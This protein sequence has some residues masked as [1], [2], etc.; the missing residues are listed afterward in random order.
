MIQYFPTDP[1]LR[2]KLSRPINETE[3]R[4]SIR[5]AA[6]FGLLSVLF[7]G[8]TVDRVHAEDK[9]KNDLYTV[10]L[11]TNE[12]KIAVEE[13]SIWMFTHFLSVDRSFPY[14]TKAVVADADAPSK[15]LERQCADTSSSDWLFQQDTLYYRK[16]SGNLNLLAKYEYHLIISYDFNSGYYNRWAPRFC[17]T[18]RNNC[19]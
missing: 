17:K 8:V 7:F 18:I 5:T 15:M 19:R 3:M 6:L 11:Y 16:I 2:N 4:K 14:I 1:G 13:R 12:G 9:T 10:A